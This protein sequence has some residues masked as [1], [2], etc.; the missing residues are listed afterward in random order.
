MNTEGLLIVRGHLLSG[1]YLLSGRMKQN[2]NEGCTSTEPEGQ[3]GRVAW[4]GE[5]V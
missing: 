2:F 1:R 3:N 5:V 4:K